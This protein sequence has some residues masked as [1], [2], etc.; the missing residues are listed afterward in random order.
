[1]GG[2]EGTVAG[3]AAA[4]VVP[5][6]VSRAVAVVVAVV[7]AN[8]EELARRLVVAAVDT[9]A[10]LACVELNAV[11]SSAGVRLSVLVEAATE[12]TEVTDVVVAVVVAVVVVAAARSRATT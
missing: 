8:G 7:V 11:V 6:D 12:V 2:E 4:V 1:M 9:W 10:L 3:L 5:A